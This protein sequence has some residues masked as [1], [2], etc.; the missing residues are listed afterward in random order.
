MVIVRML[1]SD[2]GA[3]LAFC[4]REIVQKQI[5]CLMEKK[6]SVYR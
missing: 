5:T 1:A 6:V 2:A 3:I 4:Q